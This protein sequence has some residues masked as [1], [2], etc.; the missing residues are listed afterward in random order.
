MAVKKPLIS[1]K[2]TAIE[3]QQVLT[4][5]K[6]GWSINAN[7]LKNLTTDDL[8]KRYRL[9]SQKIDPST[10][11]NPVLLKRASRINVLS[12]RDKRLSPIATPSKPKSFD[13]RTTPGVVT[14]VKDQGGCGS[15]VAFATSAAIESHYRI[16]HYN[17]M[18]EDLDLSESSLFFTAQRSCNKENLNYGWNL[19]DAF[20]AAMKEGLC[21]EYA[22]PYQDH[23]QEAIIPNGDV[24][25]VRIEGYQY[26]KSTALMKQ[27]L[28]EKGP[29][30]AD[31]TVFSDFHVFWHA[32]S[33][34]GQVYSAQ[35]SEVVGG[36][37]VCIIGYDDLRKAWLCK[38]SWG[39]SSL[40]PD[41]CFWI[42]YG[43][44]GIDDIMYIPSGVYDKYTIDKIPYNPNTL[45]IIKNSDYWT[46]T[47]GRSSMEIFATEEDAQNALKIAARHNR[48]CFVGRSNKRT[49]RKDFIFEYWEGNSGLAPQK[50]S[51][52]DEIPYNPSKVVAKYLP[53]ENYW[54]IEE[55]NHFMFIADNMADAMAMLAVVERHSKSCFI[56][57]DN[58]K[59]NRKDFIMHYFE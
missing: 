57:R 6:A 22:Y 9:G 8:A 48:Q 31:F 32:A 46:L 59:Q 1:K 4:K 51:K 10:L 58:K 28:V 44:C 36:H 40:R 12:F 53:K 21:M 43:Q 7:L 16:L 35:S 17:T 25:T 27:W 19:K 14:P 33:D 55:G 56:G 30:V 2:M 37:A 26:T 5:R 18:N 23:N 49:N 24:R 11:N 42:G 29:L 34:S 15:C 38:N 54:R 47:D 52:V 13:W 41:G 39:A 45:R 20:V 3:M 50:L